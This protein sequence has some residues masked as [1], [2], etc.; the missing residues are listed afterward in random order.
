MTSIKTQK[1]LKAAHKDGD[2]Y[3]SLWDLHLPTFWNLI[4][5]HVTQGPKS[6]KS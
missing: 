6:G 2:T 1:L 4:T 3:F 5:T